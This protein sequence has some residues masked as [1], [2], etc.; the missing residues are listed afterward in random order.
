MVVIVI[1]LIALF[2]C[3]VVCGIVA[4]AAW[5]RERRRAQRLAERLLIEG[6]LEALTLQTL[7]AMRQAARTRAPSVD[8]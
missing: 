2:A 6:R 8:G 5:R 4:V 3:W 1:G 7:Q